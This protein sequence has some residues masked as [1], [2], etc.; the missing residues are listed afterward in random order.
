MRL[1]VA[2]PMKSIAKIAR[3]GISPIIAT[4]ILISIA[5]V[6]G[7]VIWNYVMSASKPK[8][9]VRLDIVTADA[10]IAPDGSEA[11]ISLTLRNSGTVK[12]TIDNITIVYA[13]KSKTY[14]VGRDILA[15]GTLQWSFT[16]KASDLGTG[17]RYRDGDTIKI[18]IHYKDPQGNTYTVTKY[19]TLHM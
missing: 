11:T 7:F 9:V 18:V 16:S 13:G 3:R 2:I 6:A 1:A 8:T 4:I 5:V 14:T 19:L 12:I 15:G 17:I 10:T